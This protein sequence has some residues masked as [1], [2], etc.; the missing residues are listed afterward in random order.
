M[1]VLIGSSLSNSYVVVP[2]SICLL[3]YDAETVLVYRSSVSMGALK[4]TPRRGHNGVPGLLHIVLTTMIV[5]I[6]ALSQ[7][8]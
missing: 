3:L 4:A 2:T 8:I 6:E 7:I 1:F 5:S